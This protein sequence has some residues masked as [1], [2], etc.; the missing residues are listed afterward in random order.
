P[1][2]PSEVLNHVGLCVSD[3]D[4]SRR[5]YTEVLGFGHWRDFDAPDDM[6]PQLLQLPSPVGLHAV[7]LRLGEFV[8]ELLHYREAG[9]HPP[10]TPRTMNELGL[11]HLSVSVEDIPATC[12]AVL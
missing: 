5:F 8:L 1:K 3:L 11:T 2:V 6:T 4:R 7:Y 10:A 12:A 9:Q